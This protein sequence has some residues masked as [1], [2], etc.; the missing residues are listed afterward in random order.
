MNSTQT[1]EYFMKCVDVLI[2][3]GCTPTGA[4]SAAGNLFQGAIGPE[5]IIEEAAFDRLMLKYETLK[6]EAEQP[7][8]TRR[9]YVDPKELVRYFPCG[10]ANAEG[11]AEIVRAAS[12]GCG[13]SKAQFATIRQELLD[14]K[15][16]AQDPESRWFRTFLAEEFIAE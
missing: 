5:S 10:A 7:H 6:A 4:A 11:L 2:A 13:I 3:R 16:I 8:A 14:R 12:E 1:I 9:L 15:W